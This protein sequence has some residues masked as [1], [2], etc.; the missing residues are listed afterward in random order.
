VLQ[1]G[2]AVTTLTPPLVQGAVP[3]R[4]QDGSFEV[5][6]PECRAAIPQAQVAKVLRHGGTVAGQ[7]AG[8][9]RRRGGD[10]LQLSADEDLGSCEVDA[11]LAA[12]LA[13]VRVYHGEVAQRQAQALE[14][15]AVPARAARPQAPV[16]QGPPGMDCSAAARAAA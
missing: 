4:A 7:D 15:S 1:S 16:A 14:Q 2:T 11:A 10:A 3:A 5:L 6:C 12:A 13:R 8:R 9:E